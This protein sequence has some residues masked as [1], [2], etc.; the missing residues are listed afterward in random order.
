MARG[1]TP[2]LNTPDFAAVFG[3]GRLPIDGRGLL[4]HVEMVALKGTKFEVVKKVSPFSLEVR[5]LEYSESPLYLDLRFVE[6]CSSEAPE[7][8][9]ILPSNEAILE[10]LHEAVH[11]PYI[12]GGN[13][14]KGIPE[15]LTLYG[16]EEIP[17]RTLQGLDCSGLLY[18]ATNGYTPRNTGELIHFGR[19]IPTLAQIQPL[20]LIIW[21]GHVLI[22]LNPTT[23]I[24]SVIGRGVI[25]APLKERLQK[26][27]FVIRRFI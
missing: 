14:G 15:I 6:S 10:K 9:K 11:L 22:A 5:T 24:E 25:I 12:W 8:K 19:E 4:R 27:P 17:A 23:T 26:K 20:D 18:E 2:L 16:G 13:W 7:R 21:P 1:P 3:P